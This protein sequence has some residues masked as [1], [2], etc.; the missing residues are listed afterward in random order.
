MTIS[1][2]NCTWFGLVLFYLQADMFVSSLIWLLFWFL[3]FSFTSAIQ[4]PKSL[5]I[6][7]SATTYKALK[8]FQRLLLYSGRIRT[9]YLNMI[10]DILWMSPVTS[11]YLYL[12]F[13]VCLCMCFYYFQCRCF[14]V[15]FICV[16]WSINFA[17]AKGQQSW[18]LVSRAA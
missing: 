4:L 6:H 2:F 18:G 14:F 7:I 9:N 11:V 13:V 15:V 8:K 17:F 12:D 10:K 16:E 1:V 5:F 3:F